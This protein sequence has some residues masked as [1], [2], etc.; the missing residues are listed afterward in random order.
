MNCCHSADACP[1]REDVIEAKAFIDLYQAAHGQLPDEEQ[2]DCTPLNGGCAISLPR[3]PA[4]GLNRI[5]GLAKTEDLDKAYS[6]IRGRQGNRF[7]QLNLDAA[8]EEV[9]RWVQSKGLVSHGPGWAKL[10]R[11]ADLVSQLSPSKVKTRKVRPVEAMHF[12]AMM[13][14]G[15]GFPEHLAALWASI[16]GRDGWACFYA[17]DGDTPVGTGA[18]FISGP[19]AWLGGG[20]TVQSFRN[21]GVQKALIQ[22]RLQEGVAWGVS[23]FAVET[24]VPSPDKASISNANLVKM[25]FTHLYNR[26]NFILR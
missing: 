23:T 16:V 15:F 6:W 17:L 21:R 12:G 11:S 13:C 8:S 10:A 5:L 14:A 7:L 24:E 22:A 2:F 18:M 26:S 3:A 9:R 1:C 20:T 4:I 19:F 25:G